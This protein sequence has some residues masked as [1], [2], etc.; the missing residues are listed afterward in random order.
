MLDRSVPV[1]ETPLEPVSQTMLLFSPR[2]IGIIAIPGGFPVG[3]ALTLINL[4]RIGDK[5]AYARM[6]LF[7]GAATLVLVAAG[8]Y[9]PIANLFLL[10]INL[11]SAASFY[12]IG[13][14]MENHLKREGK[15][16]APEDA[17]AAI[18]MGFVAWVIWFLVFSALLAGTTYLL[19][20]FNIQL[21]R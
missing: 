4:K 3:F 8:L 9:V 1:Q 18:G 12:F 2:V 13:K 19:G 20:V 14:N 17:M 10:V 15:S 6:F 11:L 5:R 7:W 21:P 16:H